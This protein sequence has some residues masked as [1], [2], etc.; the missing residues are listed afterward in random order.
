MIAAPGGVTKTD[1][2]TQFGG[3]LCF[4]GALDVN[5]KEVQFCRGLTVA[6]MA[7]MGV[8]CFHIASCAMAERLA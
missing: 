3:S 4:E 5:R 7:V 6:S 1:G 2:R 8:G